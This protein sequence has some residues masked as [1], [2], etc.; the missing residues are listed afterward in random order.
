MSEEDRWNAF[1]ASQMDGGHGVA[2]VT[3]ATVDLND[4]GRLSEERVTALNYDPTGVYGSFTAWC[5]H[6]LGRNFSGFGGEFSYTITPP[7]PVTVLRDRAKARIVIEDPLIDT[8]PSFTDR[9]TIVRIDTWLWADPTYWVAESESE[10]AG[11]VTVEVFA[12]P[13]TMAWDFSDGTSTVCNGPGTE[14]TPGAGEPDCA[15]EF[16][17]SSAGQ[18]NDA[19]QGS[20]T[21][22]WV[23]TWTLN[24]TDQ[25]PFDTPFLATTNFE[26]QV[27]EIQAVES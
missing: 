17:R 16:T 18:P 14:W 4:Q 2:Y 26:L 7:V 3:G 19:Y 8:N 24:G 9:F 6:P 1:C 11:F 22:D 10:T 15:V 20:A 25:G 21:V 12:T 27:G 13:T 23:F 5:H